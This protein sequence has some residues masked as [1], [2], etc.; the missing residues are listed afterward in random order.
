MPDELWK[1]AERQGSSTTC[2]WPRWEQA[3][4][5]VSAARIRED[6]RSRRSAVPCRIG[7]CLTQGPTQ[8]AAGARIEDSPS[9]SS[10]LVV[11]TLYTW[12]DVDADY[13]CLLFL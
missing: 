2:I 4:G 7:P 1:E 13:R 9:L 8:V 11:G 10:R 3:G 6:H 5:P 12:I